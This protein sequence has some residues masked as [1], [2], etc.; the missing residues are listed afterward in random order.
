[1][2]HSAAN[3]GNSNPVVAT[4]ASK[5]RFPR[6]HN[7]ITLFEN[8]SNFAS[9]AMLNETFYM[10]FKHRVVAFE[11]LVTVKVQIV[12]NCVIK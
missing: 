6:I 10:I 4:S 2:I 7:S 12:N 1:M 11:T 8:Y 5:L 9:L 3:R